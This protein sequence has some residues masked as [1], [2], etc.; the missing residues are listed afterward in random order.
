MRF[1]EPTKKIKIIDFS[2]Y[3]LSGFLQEAK[4]DNLSTKQFLNFSVYYFGISSVWPK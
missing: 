3:Y 1:F 4:T 2:T